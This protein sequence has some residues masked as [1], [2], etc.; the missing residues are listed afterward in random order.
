MLALDLVHDRVGVFLHFAREDSV[1]IF[2]GCS[3]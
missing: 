3:H 2:G 1:H